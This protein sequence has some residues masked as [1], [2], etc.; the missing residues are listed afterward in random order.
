MVPRYPEESRQAGIEGRVLVS[1][2]VNADGRVD[3]ASIT[4]VERT[5][6]AFGS[7]AEL[8]A[9]SARFWPG[10]LNGVAVRVRISFPVDFRLA[11]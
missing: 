9:R 3:P 5:Y 11:R 8:F 10:C 4:I 7:E 6:W 1:A 2:T